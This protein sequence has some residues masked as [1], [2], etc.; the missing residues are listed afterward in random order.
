M[1]GH[2]PLHELINRDVNRVSCLFCR[3][4]IPTLANCSKQLS[5]LLPR[6]SKFENRPLADCVAPQLP[7]E[8][9]EDNP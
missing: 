7:P 6:F 3:V 8:T 9:V 5:R 4:G 2:V 1:S